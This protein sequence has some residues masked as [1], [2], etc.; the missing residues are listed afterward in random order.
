MP[1]LARIGKINRLCP[2]ASHQHRQA[3]ISEINMINQLK[4]TH[5]IGYQSYCAICSTHYND[6]LN[7]NWKCPNFKHI[8]R[9]P[10]P[11]KSKRLLTLIFD[12]HPVFFL[13]ELLHDKIFTYAS[14]HYI[15]TIKNINDITI[16]HFLTANYVLKKH[17]DGLIIILVLNIFYLDL[18][19]DLGHLPDSLN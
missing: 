11:E 12:N 17:Y 3:S 9:R 5:L 14:I 8:E 1:D 7:L 16:N 18:L 2:K 13:P 15:D 10:L 6:T 19:K 4:R